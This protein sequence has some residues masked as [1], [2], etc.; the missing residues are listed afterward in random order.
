MFMPTSVDAAVEL[1]LRSGGEARVLA[2]GTTFML[3]PASSRHRLAVGLARIEALRKLTITADS[4]VVGAMVTL[5]QLADDRSGRLVD[6]GLRAATAAVGNIR[7][8]NMAT[9][10]GAVV[11]A[12][13]APDPTTALV[14]LDAT[15]R[16][17]M[18][19]GPI[20]VPIA[21]MGSGDGAARGGI[22]TAIEIPLDPMRSSVHVRLTARSDPDR[23]A[24][25][26]FA[27]ARMTGGG[28]ATDIR[29][30]VGAAVHRPV[31]FADLEAAASETGIGPEARASLARGYGD[32][33]E[34]IADHRGS[35]WYRAQLIVAAVDRAL[36]ALHDTGPQ[37][38]GSAHA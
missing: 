10:G 4:V 24:V 5:Q 27:S 17:A 37:P 15:V 29:V 35:A 23:P 12:A 36:A 30:C 38:R 19:A 2:G 28:R 34:P 18:P 1:L 25:T 11:A 32:R 7:I 16:I 9:L 21:A 3:D 13:G 14:G 22:V 26:V 33:I 31:R 20:T 8:R 6:T